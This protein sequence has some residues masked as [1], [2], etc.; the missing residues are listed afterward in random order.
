MLD[1]SHNFRISTWRESLTKELLLITIVLKFY[2]RYLWIFFINTINT[3]SAFNFSSWLREDYDCT[4]LTKHY[5]N[6]FSFH[7]FILH[8]SLQFISN[9]YNNNYTNSSYCDSRLY[10]LLS[11]GSNSIDSSVKYANLRRTDLKL[12]YPSENSTH[13][14]IIQSFELVTFSPS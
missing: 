3:H 11:A 13:P 7:R 8:T 1:S 12:R 4:S 10:I 2:W 5:L 9:D 6:P 14:L